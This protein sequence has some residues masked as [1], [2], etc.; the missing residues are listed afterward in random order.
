ME[1]I[2]SLAHSP[3]PVMRS[4]IYSLAGSWRQWD[5][6]YYS[7][8]L[9][10]IIQQHGQREPLSELP[11]LSVPG[12]KTEQGQ[13]AQKAWSNWRLVC[14]D[15]TNSRRAPLPESSRRNV[16]VWYK[17]EHGKGEKHN[18]NLYASSGTSH[19]N[20]P[21]SVFMSNTLDSSD[22]NP[23][24][25]FALGIYA[26]TVLCITGKHL[27]GWL[28]DWALIHFTV[29]ML[30]CIMLPFCENLPHPHCLVWTSGLWDYVIV[31]FAY[32]D[33]FSAQCMLVI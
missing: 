28:S 24:S 3:H 27:R 14:W 12:E 4:S 16:S 2:Q 13:S 17:R 18:D 21:L 22:I 20:H 9:R 19:S 33:I 10:S 6:W 11:W 1:S 26:W 5:L 30:S 8:S 29:M 15:T 32:V 23:S 7:Y 25:G 31:V